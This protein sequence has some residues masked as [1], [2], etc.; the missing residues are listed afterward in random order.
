MLYERAKG[1]ITPIHED[2]NGYIFSFFCGDTT[3]TPTEQ[4]MPKGDKRGYVCGCKVR[5]TVEDTGNGPTLF[6][7]SNPESHYAAKPR[8]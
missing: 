8:G 6:F 3:P 2:E 7:W 1:P 5:I 4:S